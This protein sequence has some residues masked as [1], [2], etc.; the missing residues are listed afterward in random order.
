[1]NLTM[2]MFVEKIFE[3]PAAAKSFLKGTMSRWS[4][5]HSFIAHEV[6]D[7]VSLYYEGAS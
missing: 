5:S 4:E 1:M 2:S 3:A 6:P 7:T